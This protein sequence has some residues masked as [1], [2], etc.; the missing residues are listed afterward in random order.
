[1]LSGTQF[2]GLAVVACAIALAVFEVFYRMRHKKEMARLQTQPDAPPATASDPDQELKDKI[3]QVAI[4][5][6]GQEPATVVAN[7]AKIEK[8]HKGRIV[9]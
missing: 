9:R 8:E 2:F 1:M 5:R 6:G 3:F 7:I 4:N